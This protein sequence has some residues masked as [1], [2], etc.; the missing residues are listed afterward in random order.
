MKMSTMHCIWYKLCYYCNKQD[1]S[2][3][4]ISMF[5]VLRVKA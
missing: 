3:I 1:S 5:Y 4:Y 2:Q